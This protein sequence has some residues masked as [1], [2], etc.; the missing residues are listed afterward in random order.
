MIRGIVRRIGI[1]SHSS[2]CKNSCKT[3]QGKQTYF[4]IPCI[5]RRG[6]ILNLLVSE[7]DWAS[8]LYVV[9]FLYIVES[10][11]IAVV[12]GSNCLLGSTSKGSCNCRSNFLSHCRGSSTMI[13]VVGWPELA[14][15]N[16]GHPIIF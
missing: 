7:F 10:V 9:D 16:A 2:H 12:Q 13:H 1:V 14:C 11:L 3:W 5:Q 15:E 6:Y 4:S 8:A